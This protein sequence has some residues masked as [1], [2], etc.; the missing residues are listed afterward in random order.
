MKRMPLRWF[1]A[2]AA[3]LALVQPTL[4]AD[5]PSRSIEWVVPYPAGG[6]TDIVARVLSDTMSKSLGQPIVVANKPGAATAIGASHTARA[7][8]DGYT[9]MSADTATLAANPFLYSKLTYDPAE[10]FTEIGLTVRFPLILAVNPKVPANNLEE[11]LAWAKDQPDGVNYGTP[12]AGSPHHL[13]TELFRLRTGLDLVHVPYRGAAPAVQ[14]V[15]SGQIPFMFIDSA[16]GQQHLAAGT[17]RGIGVAS[18]ERLDSFPDI[19]T[20]SEQGVADFEAYAWQGLVA[21]KGVPEAVVERLN[22][23]L[24]EALADPAVVERFTA[25]GLEITPSSPAEMTAYSKAEREKWGEVI[26]ESKITLE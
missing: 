7:K 24:R 17:L 21:P 15:L 2:I 14:D 22:K 26:R 16:G 12:G 23:D 10:D 3:S 20:L 5:Y 1:G 25:M 4:A 19:P 18:A 9:I 8:P 6:G 13:A 11:F